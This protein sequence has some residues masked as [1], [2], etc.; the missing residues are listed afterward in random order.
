MG[1]GFKVGGRVRGFL[2]GR[3][4]CH[5]GFVGVG[6][7]MVA[8]RLEQSKK[9]HVV[10]SL[11]P[12]EFRHGSFEPLGYGSVPFGIGCFGRWLGSGHPPSGAFSPKALNQK[13]GTY[14]WV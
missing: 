14:P 4:V 1:L 13:L 9:P 6:W 11:A 8:T 5:V 7:R 2:Q 10:W 3:F 12:K